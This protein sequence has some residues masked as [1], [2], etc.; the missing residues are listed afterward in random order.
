MPYKSKQYQMDLYLCVVFE[1][2]CISVLC[3]FVL[4]SYFLFFVMEGGA[5]W[6]APIITYVESM[7]YPL[8]QELSDAECNQNQSCSPLVWVGGL[9]GRTLGSS[10][11]WFEKIRMPIEI[12]MPNVDVCP[13]ILFNI[14]HHNILVFGQSKSQ[15]TSRT[16]RNKRKTTSE[17]QPWP[18]VRVCHDHEQDPATISCPRP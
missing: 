12:R 8:S 5:V 18:R 15:T 4:P 13:I 9:H 1:L 11:L 10:S 16:H 14:Q 3:K 2:C 6:E 7:M 17:T